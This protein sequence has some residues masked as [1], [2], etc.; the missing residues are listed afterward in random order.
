[1]PTSS[2]RR[3][4]TDHDGRSPIMTAV[5]DHDVDGRT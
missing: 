4:I 1:M 2:M 3:A 5:I